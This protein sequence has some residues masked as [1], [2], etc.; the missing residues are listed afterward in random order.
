MQ[1]SDW[2]NENF[3]KETKLSYQNC[4]WWGKIECARPHQ[5][6][7]KRYCLYSRV[8]K[9][10]WA[11]SWF[12]KNK[13]YKQEYWSALYKYKQ[14]KGEKDI[15][16]ER[17]YIEWQHLCPCDQ[18]RFDLC[19]RMD[20]DRLHLESEKQKNSMISEN[21]TAFTFLTQIIFESNGKSKI[22]TIKFDGYEGMF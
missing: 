3:Q 19:A 9:F 6:T 18:R 13:D 11:H 16:V 15:I 21:P 12:W 14:E 17:N 7:L 2:M 1:K 20:V 4:I 5:N 22:T 10:I 8:C